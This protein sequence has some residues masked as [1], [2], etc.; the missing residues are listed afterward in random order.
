MSDRAAGRPGVPA[1]FPTIFSPSCALRDLRLPPTPRAFG[2]WSACHLGSLPG[3]QADLS[4]WARASSSQE[5]GSSFEPCSI[6]LGLRPCTIWLVVRLTPK[7]TVVRAEW[8]RP[9]VKLNRRW[10][11]DIGRV[12]SPELPESLHPQASICKEKCL[13]DSYLSP[14][15]I[16]QVRASPLKIF[17]I[18][19]TEDGG[20]LG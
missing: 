19:A 14:T 11:H 17:Y 20:L 7:S 2:F 3:L 5:T 18:S 13:K 1:L 15:T 6:L 8:A 9:W 16:H 4:F 12:F 10:G